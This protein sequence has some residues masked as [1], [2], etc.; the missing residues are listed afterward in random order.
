M[1]VHV[2]ELG[3]WGAETGG[4]LRLTGCLVDTINELYVQ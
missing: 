2:C 3:L 4:F 1:V